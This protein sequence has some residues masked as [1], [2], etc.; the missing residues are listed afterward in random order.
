MKYL[1]IETHQSFAI[2]L[3]EK[4]LF[5]NA[6]NLNYDV[7]QTVENPFI[8][9]QEPTSGRDEIINLQKLKNNRVITGLVALVAVVMLIFGLSTYRNSV[10]AVSSIY[11]TINPDVQIQLNSN[12]EVI[13][14]VSE[15]ED[16]AALIA[17]YEKTTKDKTIVTNELI[18]LSIAMGF[19]EDGGIIS[20]SI[21]TS[22][23][24]LF[25]KYGVEL[26]RTVREHLDGKI[27]VTIEV[28]NREE[29]I[30][31]AKQREEDAQRE[32]DDTEDKIPTTQV[33]ETQAPVTPE[34]A[35]QAP[36]TQAPATQTP[37]PVPT[38]APIPSNDDD[39]DDSDDDSD[40]YDDDDD[41]Y[42]D[43]NDDDDSDDDD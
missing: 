12:G 7:G 32:V 22:D 8:M 37:A 15:N 40:D 27:S 23:Q 10:Q 25:K 2:L 31:N 9:G 4:G 28:T 6:A 1:V 21:E 17:N 5:Y 33:P 3:D 30:K 24:E 35:T 41:D 16:G 26:R 29:A 34:P 38:P 20:I 14:L 39:D 18:D 11:L 19:L 36:A 43:D 13:N 42:D